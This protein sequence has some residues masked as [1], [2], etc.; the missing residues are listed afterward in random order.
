MGSAESPYRR[1]GG[2]LKV[3]GVLGSYG[4]SRAAG[5]MSLQPGACELL[6]A[7]A[8]HGSGGSG[9]RRRKELRIEHLGDLVLGSFQMRARLMIC[10]LRQRGRDRR[11]Q[12]PQLGA[13]HGL[14]I[15][16]G[17]GPATSAASA[18]G[19]LTARDSNRQGGDRGV[20][21]AIRQREVGALQT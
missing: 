4:P 1:S 6:A 17:A 3:N 19:W 9:G 5:N 2:S 13:V 12:G 20:E 10:R 15:A 8:A 21:L 16:A 14:L 7:A 11:A 18:R